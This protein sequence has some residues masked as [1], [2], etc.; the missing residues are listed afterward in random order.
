M[1]TLTWHRAAARLPSFGGEARSPYSLEN[2]PQAL[3]ASSPEVPP[4]SLRKEVRFESF[5][6]LT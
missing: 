5:K 2:H 6:P 4:S 1:P 3:G